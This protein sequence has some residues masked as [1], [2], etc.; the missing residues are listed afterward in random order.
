MRVVGTVPG[1]H[2]VLRQEGD[3]QDFGA[4][5]DDLL[6]G[7]GHRLARDPVHLVEGMRP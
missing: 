7:C 4:G 1:R 6:A 5:D 2:V 3:L